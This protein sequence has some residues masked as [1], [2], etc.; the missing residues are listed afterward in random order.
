MTNKTNPTTQESMFLGSIPSASKQVQS[1]SILR[2]ILTNEKDQ[3]DF[4]QKETV[5]TD[6]YRR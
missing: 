6:E 4:G 3:E 2:T 5:D 1:Q